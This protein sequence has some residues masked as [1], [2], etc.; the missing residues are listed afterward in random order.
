MEHDVVRWKDGEWLLCAELH[1]SRAEDALCEAGNTRQGSVISAEIQVSQDLSDLRSSFCLEFALHMCKHSIPSRLLA[2]CISSFGAAPFGVTGNLDLC[3]LRRLRSLPEV[4]DLA[5]QSE[6]NGRHIGV[7]IETKDPTLHDSVGLPLEE[8][9]IHTLMKAGYKETLDAPVILPSFVL[10]CSE[11]DDLSHSALRKLMASALK[12]LRPDIDA[13]SGQFVTC[14]ECRGCSQHPSRCS[15]RH[16]QWHADS[17]PMSLRERCMESPCEHRLPLDMQSADAQVVTSQCS[18]LPHAGKVLR[19]GAT[20]YAT[21]G[22][23]AVAWS[24]GARYL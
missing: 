19:H 8:R 21:P 4:L 24:R 23:P 12:T 2:H 20:L 9:V 11:G 5:M 15:Q 10:T 17:P 3:A 7:Y 16:Y 14:R 13:T 22:F 18:N 6:Q 1:F